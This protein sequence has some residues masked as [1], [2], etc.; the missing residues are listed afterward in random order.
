[1]NESE[2]N[3]L[4]NSMTKKVQG[5]GLTGRQEAILPNNEYYLIEPQGNEVY[6]KLSAPGKVLYRRIRT[7]FPQNGGVPV[8][9]TLITRGNANANDYITNTLDMTSPYKKTGSLV[10]QEV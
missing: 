1:M 4:I 9:D 8:L 7:R 2:I 3:K 5:G 6:E 10:D